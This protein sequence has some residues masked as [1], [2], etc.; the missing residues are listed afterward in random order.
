MNQ[1]FLTFIFFWNE[2]KSCKCELPPWQNYKAHSSMKT[3]NA[4]SGKK[5]NEKTQF[6]SFEIELLCTRSPIFQM[7]SLVPGD[8]Y[9]DMGLWI[10]KCS[11]AWWTGDTQCGGNLFKAARFGGNLMAFTDTSQV[12]TWEMEA[13]HW[14]LC[15]IFLPVGL[16][17]ED[18][19]AEVEVCSWDC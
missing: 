8:P 9:S 6:W 2:K 11:R 15:F 3:I 18:L 19:E 14:S 1:T 12:S 17:R 16:A 4:K 10:R 7:S 13:W 5:A